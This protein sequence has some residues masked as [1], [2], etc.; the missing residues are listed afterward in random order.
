MRLLI[1]ILL[2]ISLQSQGQII[3][4]N[5]FYRPPVSGCSYLLDQYSGNKVAL[6]LRKVK[7]GY[8]GALVRIRRTND[9]SEQDIYPVSGGV[10]I[11]TSAILSFVGS[12]S[13]YVVKWYNQSGF[14][15]AI[16]VVSSQQARIVN[17]GTIERVNGKVAVYAD[18]GDLYA[19][20]SLQLYTY[21]AT[22][23]VSKSSSP[24]LMVEHS[25]NANNNDGFYF[26]QSSNASWIVRRTTVNYAFGSSDWA[27][28]NQVISSLQYNSSGGVYY[29]NG[30]A[31][32]NVAVSGSTLS[33]TQ[34]TKDLYILARDG[35]VAPLTGY[36]QELLLWDSD[37]SA[38][39]TAIEANINSYY[40]VY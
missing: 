19:I 26:Y 4:A 22:F 33:N 3:R 13:A 8:T 40:S 28:T 29:K 16:T 23:V 1:A 24:F 35:L 17:A 32:S 25:A 27:G 36:F 30:A 5:P 6:S 2:F 39:R 37:Q 34:T 10:E 20:A 18:G 9:N 15:D 21:N 31:Q 14:G 38:N 12:N 7:C 11:D